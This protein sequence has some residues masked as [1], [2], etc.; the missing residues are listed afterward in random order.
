MRLGTR[1]CSALALFVIASAPLGLAASECSPPFQPMK[2]TSPA[3]AEGQRIPKIYTAD[4][5]DI[6]PPLLW[7]GVPKHAKKLVLICDDP[8]APGG[9][10]VHWVIYDLLPQS[11]GMPEGMNPSRDLGDGSRQGFNGFHKVGYN[12]PSPPAGKTHRYFF[13]LYAV[14]Q[15]LH[16]KA[17]ATVD[18]VMCTMQG[19]IMAEAKLMGV[20]SR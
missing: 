8:D 7:T 4:G 13:K 3:F 9:T 6:S 15:R 18:Q 16:L 2:I 19:H 14:N 1:I 12:G 5:S 20:Y 17:R 10:F 11:E